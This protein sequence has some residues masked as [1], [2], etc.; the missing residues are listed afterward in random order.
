MSTKTYKADLK[1]SS[2]VHIHQTQFFI[3]SLSV[4]LWLKFFSSLILAKL[5][6]PGATSYKLRFKYLLILFSSV[7]LV[8]CDKNEISQSEQGNENALRKA[9]L[10]EIVKPL[11]Q[12]VEH[13]I[14]ALGSFLPND[15]VKIAPEIACK[16]K[17]ILV[18]EGE[19]IHKGQLLVQLDDKRQKLFVN[20]AEAMIRK[21]DASLAYLE[22][23]LKRHRKLQKENAFSN[24]DYDETLS[25]VIMT[26]AR[27]N[28]LQ[29]SLDL[30]RKDLEDTKVYSPMG[31]III[32]KN[33]S[34]GEYVHIGETLLK[35]V[36][37]NPLKLH[38]TLPET[39]FDII[40]IGQKV[41]AKV[42]P[43]PDKIFSGKICF[44]NP[45]INP[46]TRAIHIKAYF[47]N[48]EGTLKPGFFAN[49]S[50]LKNVNEKAIILPGEAVIQK[51]GKHIAYVM[52]NKI[53]RLRNIRIGS[54]LG[55]KIEILSGIKPNDLVIT[56]G[57]RSVKDGDLVKVRMQ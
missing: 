29:A 6:C 19:V 33:V 9:V 5:K 17:K 39:Y 2:S 55:G 56:S 48:M 41:N 45:Q 30:S 38:F 34:E 12:R 32:E 43:Y 46:S 26:K 22:T 31:G 27:A 14:S 8:S 11:I 51:E 50:F 37:I 7:F 23:T 47:D 15:E 1:T 4:F 3:L 25:N 13:K 49:V 57:N 35:A 40:S 44:I 18:E 28:S 53:A 21:N 36:K 20:E 52:T 54:Y 42:K 10:V 24:Q 16:I